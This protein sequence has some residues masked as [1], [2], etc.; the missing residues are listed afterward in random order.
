MD[1]SRETVV[2][3]ESV[4]NNSVAWMVFERGVI[5]LGTRAC[6]N[7]VGTCRVEVF[8]VAA[9]AAEVTSIDEH[10]CEGLNCALPTNR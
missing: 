5:T 3:R 6:V 9:V 10:A 2:V 8:A 1:W 4:D 7:L